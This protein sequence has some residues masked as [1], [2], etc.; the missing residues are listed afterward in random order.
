[1]ST[2]MIA[3]LVKRNHGISKIYYIYICSGGLSESSFFNNKL[4]IIS[5][6]MFIGKLKFSIVKFRLTFLSLLVDD[7]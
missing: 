5:F 2:Q 6:V 7:K 4:S 1:M 3:G